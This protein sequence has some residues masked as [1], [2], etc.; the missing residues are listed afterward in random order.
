[1]T[2]EKPKKKFSFPQRIHHSVS[3]AHPDCPATWIIPAG[4]YDYDADGAPIPGTYHTVPP[5]P[6]KLLQ[7]RAERPHQRDVRHPG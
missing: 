2:D 6:Q 3:S 7:Q 5:N 1:M 4:S